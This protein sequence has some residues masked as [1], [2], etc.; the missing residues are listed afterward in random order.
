MPLSLP[1]FKAGRG[2]TPDK[3]GADD[4]CRPCRAVGPAYDAWRKANA[5]ASEI[6]CPHGLEI[7]KRLPM[8][9]LGDAVERVTE[10]V[11]IKSCGGCKKRRDKLN[12]LVP[13]SE[14]K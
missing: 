8:R 3:R 10:A 4:W 6:K 14:S 5:G 12:K 9:G 1:Q 7:G 2:C 13:F 11:G